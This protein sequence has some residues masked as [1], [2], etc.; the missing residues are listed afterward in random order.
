ME[1]Q[2]VGVGVEV[3]GTV[4]LAFPEKYGA[5]FTHAELNEIVK[6]VMITTSPV[7][8]VHRL[9][10][11]F[12][13]VERFN[14]DYVLWANIIAPKACPLRKLSTDTHI[15]LAYYAS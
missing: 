2:S 5:A 15:I 12:A 7:E 11:R 13:K 4:P 1:L 8:T 6:T 14:W 9:A 10:I 3:A